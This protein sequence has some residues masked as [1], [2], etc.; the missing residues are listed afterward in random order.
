VSVVVNDSLEFPAVTVCNENALM[1]SQIDVCGNGSD[2]KL[3]TMQKY[4]SDNSLTFINTT[5]NQANHTNQ[6]RSSMRAK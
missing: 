4:L 6:V 5:M 3:V 1:T 2:A